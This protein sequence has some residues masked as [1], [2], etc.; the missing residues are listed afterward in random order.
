MFISVASR[1]FLCVGDDRPLLRGKF[2]DFSQQKRMKNEFILP[3]MDLKKWF[4]SITASPF[5][6]SAFLFQNPRSATAVN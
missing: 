1:I 6:K 2:F 3:P 5:E 4:L